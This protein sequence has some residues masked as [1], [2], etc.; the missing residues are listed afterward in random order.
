MVICRDIDAYLD[1]WMFGWKVVAETTATG[2]RM[3]YG[4]IANG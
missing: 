2:G 3:Q 4:G 1:K